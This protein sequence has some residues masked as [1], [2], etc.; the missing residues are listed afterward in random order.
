ME[1]EHDKMVFPQNDDTYVVHQT[2][3]LLHPVSPLFSLEAASFW[4]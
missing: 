4:L 1:K 2:A 3:S